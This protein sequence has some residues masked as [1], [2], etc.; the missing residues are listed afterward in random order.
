[1]DRIKDLKANHAGKGRLQ[2]KWHSASHFV[3]PKG[4]S[5]NPCALVRYPHN[6]CVLLLCFGQAWQARLISESTKLLMHSPDESKIIE[7]RNPFVNILGLTQRR[8]P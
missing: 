5:K 4:T 1:M 2:S 8:K 7:Y 6:F 3:T